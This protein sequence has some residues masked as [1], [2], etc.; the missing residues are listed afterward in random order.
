[1]PSNST[2]GERQER[3]RRIRE[4]KAMKK[5]A[6]VET[7]PSPILGDTMA[8]EKKPSCK[9]N[10]KQRQKRASA[11]VTE[12]GSEKAQMESRQ[13]SVLKEKEEEELRTVSDSDSGLH[14]GAQVESTEVNSQAT[15]DVDDVI[16][17]N[18]PLESTSNSSIRTDSQNGASKVEAPL[19][20]LRHATNSTHQR[21]QRKLQMRALAQVLGI[22]ESDKGSKLKS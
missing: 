11:R 2:L 12:T 9:S 10:R 20:P 8:G 3:L 1:M 21:L 7:L 22:E 5:D 6:D 14:F 17:S 4:E 19:R 18:V 15:T 13:E 16:S